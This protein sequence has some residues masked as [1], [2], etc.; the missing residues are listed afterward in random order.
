M[1]LQRVPPCVM[2]VHLANSYYP[3]PRQ[4]SIRLA[5][6][7]LRRL[8]LVV[9]DKRLQSRPMPRSLPTMDR[10]P[11]KPRLLATLLLVGPNARPP[12]LA[13]FVEVSLA[14]APLNELVQL[15]LHGLAGRRRASEIPAEG[16]PDW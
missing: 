9:L 12:Q 11:L 8:F 2:E 13:L 7:Q 3:L 10:V 1:P 16:R 4:A 5:V 6:H 14:R 15:T